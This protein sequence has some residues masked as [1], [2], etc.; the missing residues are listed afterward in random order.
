VAHT[1]V[2]STAR[3]RELPRDYCAVELLLGAAAGPCS[4]AIH[5]HHVDPD[6]PDSRT[7]PACAGHHSRL[8]VVV[9]LLERGRRREC[10]HPHR[11]RESREACERKLNRAA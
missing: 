9:R 6:D 4:G 11:T 8:H 5:R 2:Y 1:A 10:P 7:L 3:W